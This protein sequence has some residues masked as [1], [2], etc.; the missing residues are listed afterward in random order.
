MTLS[1]ATKVRSSDKK[2]AD[3][4]YQEPAERFVFLESKRRDEKLSCMIRG[5]YDYTYNCVQALCIYSVEQQ[6]TP[7]Q[8]D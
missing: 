1:H 3:R 6:K 8:A 2:S 7:W 4:P 5:E